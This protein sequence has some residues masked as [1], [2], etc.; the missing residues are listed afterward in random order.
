MDITFV[1]MLIGAVIG[2]IATKL[3]T[4]LKAGTGYFRISPYQG[5]E[6]VSTINVR[7][8]NDPNLTKKKIIIL[9][10]EESSQK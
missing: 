10:R 7:I 6:G 4:D 8:P 9:H 1:A 5:E 3:F 2:T